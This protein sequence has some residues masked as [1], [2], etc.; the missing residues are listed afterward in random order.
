[1]IRFRDV[2]FRKNFFSL[3]CGQI[4]SEFGDRLNQMALISLVY[5]KS[6]GSVMAMA[7]L[8]FFIVIP[9]FVIGPVAGVYVDRWDRKK[10][11]I[12][13]D[14]LRGVLV[15]CI[16]FFVIFNM[17]LPI[18]I[19][20]FLMFSATRFFLPSKLA[21]IPAIV[22]EEKLMVAN[23]LSNVTRMIAT[24]LGF[25]LAGFIVKWVGHM[26]GFYLDSI[27]YFVSA[28]L[29]LL[30][31]PRKDLKDVKSDIRLTRELIGHSI[32]RNVWSDIGEG[33]RHM[34]GKDKM[35]VVTSTLILLM[36]GAGSIFCVIIVFVQETF[37]SITEA[38][39]IL[40]VFLGVGLFAGTMIY[41]RFGQNLSKI[42]TMF[43]CFALS[44]VAIGMFAVYAQ[45][46]PVFFSAGLMIMLAGASAAPILTCTNT[47]IHVLVPDDV[48]GRIFSSMEAVM[49][50][51]FLIFMFLT[52]Y[53][54]RYLSNFTIL[55]ASGIVFS[56]VGV[57]GQVVTR[58]VKNNEG[59]R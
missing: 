49:H 31:T 46:S 23:S 11:M 40:G 13:A 47:L 15:L 52:A 45:R 2:L 17:T 9:V 29:I 7:K 59:D 56:T 5:S 44:G 25:A 57:I 35:K 30:I 1:M 19:V 51:A 43:T 50:T 8:L 28:A 10:V 38:L 24:I 16:P 58:G 34:M 20:V 53:L 14:V 33:F 41:G 37:G 32:R 48:R 12:I 21:L 55:L 36:A 54:S 6:P 39:G 26:W 27:S 3:W 42:R 18:Y 22:S 4:I